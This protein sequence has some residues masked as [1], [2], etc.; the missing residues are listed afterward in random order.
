MQLVEAVAQIAGACNDLTDRIIAAE[1][2]LESWHQYGGRRTQVQD[3]GRPHSL[4][5][6]GTYTAPLVL[7]RYSFLPLALRLLSSPKR[8]SELRMTLSMFILPS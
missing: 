1:R 2:M 3:S 5:T 8:E 4:M 7:A 6:V